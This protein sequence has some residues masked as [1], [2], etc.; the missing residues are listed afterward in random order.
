MPGLRGLLFLYYGHIQL[1]TNFIVY[2]STLVNFRFAPTITTYL[3]F[4]VQSI[5]VV[6][7]IRYRNSINLSFFSTV[8]FL[9]VLIGLPQSAEV[10]ATATNLHFHFSLL[11][12]LL[13]AI[14]VS[15]NYPKF[16]FRF[17][18]LLSGLSGIPANFLFPVYMASALI[19]RDRERIIQAG[20][21]SFT[22]IIQ[23]TLLFF[24]GRETVADR[25]G[26]DIVVMWF[27]ILAQQFIAPISGF[28]VTYHGLSFMVG[29]RLTDLLLWALLGNIYAIIFSI[30]CSIPLF[31][32]F[33]SAVRYK[34][35]EA[36]VLA[37]SMLF[38]AVPSCITS[39]GDKIGAVSWANNGRYFYVP[40]ALMVLFVLIV[41]S[42]HKS[43]PVRIYLAALFLSSC[44]NVPAYFGGKPWMQA[45]REAIERHKDQVE[46]WP[47]G[48]SMPLP[49]KHIAN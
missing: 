7:L 46:I 10:W 33:I 15:V 8:F 19:E 27:S 26:F 41:F 22:T 43:Y 21:I 6:L 5:P 32:F 25:L 36:L 4:S 18:L 13:L 11:S 12:A 23:L 47:D 44:V 31:Y 14:P 37:S 35:R 49:E 28:Y 24:Y 9:I 29:G 40:N 2:I 45:Y 16:I 20:I 48:W 42:R 1:V 34:T 30:V 39:L 17:L 38:I 3:A